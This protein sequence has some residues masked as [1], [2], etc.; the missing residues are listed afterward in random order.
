MK[1][2]PHG[3]VVLIYDKRG[4][5]KSSGTYPQNEGWS[6][7]HIASCRNMFD[8]LA[9]DALA[10]FEWLKSRDQID[11]SRIGLAGI[12]QAGWI[13]PL[14][15]SRTDDVAFI[16]SISGPAV[17]CG[18]EDWYSQLT[19]EYSAFPEFGAPTSYAKGELTDAEIEQR[20]DDY[21]GPQGYDPVPVLA[22]LRVPILWLNGG[23]DRSTP[24]SRTVANVERLIAEG[25]PFELR[26][27]PEGN[28]ILGGRGG[29]FW[30][31][32]DYWSDVRM[33]LTEKAVLKQP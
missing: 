14:V 18:M 15:A 1:L 22:N 10:G 19:G 11:S 24:T 29:S 2:V 25:A 4:V 23:R 7:E 12:S 27:Y 26:V 16:V 20:L 13:M 8:L 3:M 9:G 30:R 21:E 32:Y 5:G 28:H 31:F 17:S 33:W 6:A